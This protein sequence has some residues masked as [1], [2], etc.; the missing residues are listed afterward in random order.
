MKATIFLRL[1]FH[2]LLPVIIRYMN[3]PH[4]TSFSNCKRTN[5]QYNRVLVIL[6]LKSGVNAAQN[7]YIVVISLV[8]FIFML[9]HIF[10]RRRHL[11]TK[12]YT[13]YKNEEFY[14]FWSVSD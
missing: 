12:W 6:M 11:L 5:L 8:W 9:C 3:W 1:G 13:V 10:L 2:F 7:N 4:F 14:T